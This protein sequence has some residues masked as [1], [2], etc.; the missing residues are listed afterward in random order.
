MVGPSAKRSAYSYLVERYQASQRIICDTIGVSRT[1]V[2]YVRTKDDSITEAKLEELAEKYPTRGLDT[3]YGMIRLE[4]LKW[5]RK[6]VIRVY[7]KLGLQLRRKQKKRINRPYNEGLSQPIMPNETWSI[8]FMSD[9]LEDGRKIRTFNVI[10]DYNRQCLSI[11][12]GISMPST[13]VTRILD[14]IIEIYGKPRSIRCDNGPEFTAQ[15]LEQW[16]KEN[17]IEIKYIQPGKPNQNGF[18]ERFNRT[19]REDILDA[20]LFSD[21]EQLQLTTDYWIDQYNTK[22]PHQ[23]LGGMSPVE[24]RYSRRKVID[25]YESVKAKMNG[26]IEPALTNSTP[27][28]GYRYMNIS[29]KKFNFNP[30]QI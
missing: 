13:R 27:S 30:V 16:A 12:A 14:Q 15:H 24:F 18:V 23:S 11:K 4:G 2:R 8:D 26:S 5:N 21:L 1:T 25:A 7:R 3:Y 22:Y 19:Y 6:R 9:A 29:M 17:E 28:M 10:D 20:Y